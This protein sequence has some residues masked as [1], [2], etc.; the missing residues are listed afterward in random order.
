MPTRRPALVKKEDIS[1]TPASLHNW[2]RNSKGR[3]SHSIAGLSPLFLIL[4]YSIDPAITGTSIPE[5]YSSELRHTKNRSFMS[6]R[7]DQI[8]VTRRRPAQIQ[9]PNLCFSVSILFI[10]VYPV[11]FY[12]FF[13]Y[14]CFWLYT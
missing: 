10:C 13:R 8:D 14:D 2:A 7:K 12:S 3:A 5:E 1:N 6:G 9:Y 4:E 11:C